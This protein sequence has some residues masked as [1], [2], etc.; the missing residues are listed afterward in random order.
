L[1]VSGDPLAEKVV[2]PQIYHFFRPLLEKK[3]VPIGVFVL[4]RN[5]NFNYSS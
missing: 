1:F 5:F 4:G 3:A 2:T